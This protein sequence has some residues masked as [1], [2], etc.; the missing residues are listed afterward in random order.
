MLGNAT[1]ALL[2]SHMTE[3]KASSPPP[4]RLGVVS[5]LNTL[6]LIEGLGASGDLE[7]IPA[8]PAQLIGML[9]SG[10]ADAAL[11]SV[12]DAAKADP[13][14][15]LM[16]SGM[17][18]CDGPTLT[19]RVFSRVPMDRIE[20]LH[21][22]VESHTSVALARVVLAKRFGAAPTIEAFDARSRSAEDPWPEAVLLIGD[23][24]VTGAPPEGAYAH[25]LDLGEAWKALTGGPFVYAVW[26]CRS[27]DLEDAERAGRLRALALML[28]RA[29]RH[30]QTRLD[31]TV[32]AHAPAHGWTNE[33]ASEYVGAR[34]RYEVTD[35]ARDAIDEFWRA[36][37]ELGVIP[38]PAPSPVWMDQGAAG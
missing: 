36:C 19:V 6:P 26:M 2:L 37:A 27:A 23:K 25:E 24:V 29:R 18:G 21:A 38:A 16:R 7:L 30:N 20:T 33:Q 28:D 8:P 4:L 12:I 11:A 3:N 15:T 14:V 17:I 1:P 5:Y 34:L 13:A 35:A 22:D 9:A 32:A 31:W 10:E